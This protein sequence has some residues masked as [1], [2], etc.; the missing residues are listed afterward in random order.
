MREALENNFNCIEDS[1][2]FYET[3]I[4]FHPILYTIPENPI[5]AEILLR[6][7][8][9]D[10]WAQVRETFEQRKGED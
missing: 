2:K 5:K 4:A 10:A 8:L 1:E 6:Q 7:H 9:D 3:E